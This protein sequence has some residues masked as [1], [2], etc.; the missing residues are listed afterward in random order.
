VDESPE[1]SRGAQPGTE[2][3]ESVIVPR[4]ADIGGFAVRRALPSAQRQ[5]VGPFIFADQMGPAMLTPGTGIDVRPHPHINLATVTYLFE[6]ELLHRDSLG[7]TQL[8]RPG[9]VNWMTAGRG[10]VHSERT[11][12]AI[13][14]RGGALSGL[15]TWVAL[16]AAA[17]ETAPTFAHYD[18]A[19]LPAIEDNDKVVRLIAGTLYGEKSP[20]ATFSDIF[21]AYAQLASGARLPLDPDHEERAIYTLTGDVE[22]AGERFAPGRL[23]LFRPGDRITVS[24]AGSAGLMLLGGA[25]LEG[26][27]YIWWNFVSSRPERIRQAGADWKAGRFPSVP[28]DERE[29]IPL[30]DDK[31]FAA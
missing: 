31:S 4:L 12:P 3:I 21:Y 10:I 25:S 20:V 26:R 6:G 27:R 13:R 8:I 11:P 16:P 1:T 17:E 24:A 30:P 7:N 23:L 14:A 22:I 28:G 5:M 19:A 2:P 15:Q 9:E 18:R 29:F